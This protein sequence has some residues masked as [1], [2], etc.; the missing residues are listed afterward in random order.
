MKKRKVKI[1]IK[2]LF[3]VILS[4]MALQKIN[5][6]EDNRELRE[7]IYKYL[8][9][10]NNRIETYYS[11]VALNNGKSENTCVYFISEVLRKNN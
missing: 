3:V 4:I 9:D 7:N 5:A 11:G 10:K 8:Q 6:V 1:I 2:F